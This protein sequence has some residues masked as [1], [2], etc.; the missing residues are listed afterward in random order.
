MSAD[1]DAKAQQRATEAFQ[2][3]QDFARKQAEA[4]YWRGER[5]KAEFTS[6]KIALARAERDAEACERAYV[7]CSS[8]R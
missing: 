4:D 1:F 7:P 2:R 6:M 3:N 8:G 5:E